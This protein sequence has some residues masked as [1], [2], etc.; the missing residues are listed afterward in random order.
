M[1]LSSGCHQ[2]DPKQIASCQAAPINIL[3]LHLLLER[4]PAQCMQCGDASAAQPLGMARAPLLSQGGQS[5]GMAMRCASGTSAGPSSTSWLGGSAVILALRRSNSPAAAAGAALGA[6]FHN[7]V[8]WLVPL[9][10]LQAQGNH[11]HVRQCFCHARSKMSRY[12]PAGRAQQALA[13]W[14]AQEPR[15]FSCTHAGCAVD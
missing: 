4:H 2:Y 7:T 1:I 6:C 3:N 14:L 13:G 9:L 5:Q 11:Y 8:F 12:P 10:D 15:I